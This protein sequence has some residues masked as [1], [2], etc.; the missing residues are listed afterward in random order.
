L[1]IEVTQCAGLSEYGVGSG[2]IRKETAES[3]FT[4]AITGVIDPAT[5]EILDQNMLAE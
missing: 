4:T 2:L 1:L 5:R 3:E